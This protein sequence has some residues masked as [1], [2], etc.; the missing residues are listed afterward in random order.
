MLNKFLFPFKLLLPLFLMSGICLHASGTEGLT[1]ISGLVPNP[2]AA[3]V[4]MSLTAAGY[5]F[6]VSGLN[7]P[8]A[9]SATATLSNQTR[10]GIVFNFPAQTGT[11]TN[12]ILQLSDTGGNVLWTSTSNTQG[13]FPIP[14]VWTPSITTG[15][16][17]ATTGTLPAWSSWQKTVQVPLWINGMPLASGTYTLDASVNGT[18]E[19]GAT[20]SFS[21]T[22]IKTGI[23]GLVQVATYGPI[24]IGKLPYRPVPNAVV[25]LFG[26]SSQTVPLATTTTN[27]NGNFQFAVAPGNYVVSTGRVPAGYVPSGYIVTSG[28]ATVTEGSLAD[29]SLDYVAGPG[30]PIPMA[31]PVNGK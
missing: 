29:V 6:E 21:V 25:N 30:V 17:T 4:T 22:G 20:V 1:P 19:F 23:V 3:G 26:S 14:I 31:V 11:W 7:A 15:T 9:F 10:E 24:F 18:P 28:S 16:A 12:F 27:A 2:G 8:A 13:I 5:Q